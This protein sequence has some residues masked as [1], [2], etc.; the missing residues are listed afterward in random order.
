MSQNAI[1]T[2][3]AA[4]VM[5]K[6][7]PVAYAPPWASTSAS[8]RTVTTNAIRHSTRTRGRVARAQFGAIP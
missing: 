7:T 4:D 2:A 3:T 6:S 1:V 5:R 8:K